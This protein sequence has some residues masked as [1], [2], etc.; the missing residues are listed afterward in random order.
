M[1][2]KIKT[3][4]ELALVVQSLKQAGKKIVTTNGC[5][6]LMHAGHATYLS[7]AKKH[8]DVLIVGLNSDTSVKRYKGEGRPFVNEQDRALLIASLQSVDFVTVFDEDTP[9]KLLETIQPHIHA[10]GGDYDVEKMPESETVK[11]GGGT[12]VAI[13]LV[14]GRSTTALVRRIK[15][16][17]L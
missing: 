5:F 10:K 7:D 4:E 2:D 11:N 1:K 9:V 12:L 14:D 6:D 3:K 16:K 8:G 15:G 13:P 17:P